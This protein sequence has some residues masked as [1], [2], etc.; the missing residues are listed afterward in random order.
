MMDTPFGFNQTKKENVFVTSDGNYKQ[1]DVVSTDVFRTI[2]S[3]YAEL[4]GFTQADDT[5]AIVEL[6]Q[7]STKQE[8]L[9]RHVLLPEA[10]PKFM[11]FNVRRSAELNTKLGRNSTLPGFGRIPI[12]TNVGTDPD[13]QEYRD[14]EM[15][16]IMACKYAWDSNLARWP[17]NVSTYSDEV[18]FKDHMNLVTEMKAVYAQIFELTSA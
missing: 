11:P 9:F 7:L 2:Q 5:K 3:G 13:T 8:Q 16:N 6:Q 14:V 12:H 17:D 1:V 4:L 10:L 15:I 18:V